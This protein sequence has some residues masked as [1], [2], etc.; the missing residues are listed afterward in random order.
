MAYLILNSNETCDEPENEIYYEFDSENEAVLKRLWHCFPE[1][2][3][4]VNGLR[5]NLLSSAKRVWSKRKFWYKR[6]SKRY[7]PLT[8]RIKSGFQEYHAS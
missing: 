8:H 5:D 2:D 6:F 4:E 1:E 3:L 7:P